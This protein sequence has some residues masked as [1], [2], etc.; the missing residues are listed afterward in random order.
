MKWP[1]SFW[2]TKEGRGVLG[3]DIV[4]VDADG[5]SEVDGNGVDLGIRKCYNSYSTASVTHSHIGLMTSHDRLM[6][7]GYEFGYHDARS[8]SNS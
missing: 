7:C 6:I 5:G 4:A 2:G 3:R 1:C 8:H